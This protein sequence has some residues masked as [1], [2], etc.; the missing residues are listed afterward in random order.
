MP[1]VK[2]RIDEKGRVFKDFIGFKGMSCNE[3]DRIID[4]KVPNLI[5][6]LKAQKMKTV[7]QYEKEKEHT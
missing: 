6:K 3:A 2:V 5:T 7:E 1:I 4:S